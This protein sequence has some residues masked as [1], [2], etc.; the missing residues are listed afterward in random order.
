MHLEIKCFDQSM[1]RDYGLPSVATDGSAAIDLPV[2]ADWTL[3]ENETVDIPTGYGIHLNEPTMCGLLFVR[4]GWS[5]YISLANGVGVIDSDYQGQIIARV[6]A[7][8]FARVKRGQCIVQYM[9]VPIRRVHELILVPE[10][11]QS[12]ARGEGGF[13]STGS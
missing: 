9:V 10:F 12:S 8:E 2:A 7:R 1:Y 6:Y 13:G 4:S 11:S 5:K 3:R